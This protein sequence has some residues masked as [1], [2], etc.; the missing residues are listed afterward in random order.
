MLYH[1]IWK[2]LLT[3]SKQ[4]HGSVGNTVASGKDRLAVSNRFYSEP[5]SSATC[6]HT[7]LIFRSKEQVDNE[8]ASQL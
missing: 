4:K 2:I 8:D 1:L 6:H 7:P 5:A 3:T